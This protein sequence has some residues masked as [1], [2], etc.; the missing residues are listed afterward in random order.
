MGP[1]GGGFGAG[2]GFEHFGAQPGASHAHMQPQPGDPAAPIN[3]MLYGAGSGF[4]RSGLGAYGERLFG[5]SRDYVQSNM[6]RY[7]SSQD[8]P[9]YF[10][11][12][13][14][15]VRN[16]LKVILCPFLHKGHWTRIAEQVAGGLTYKPPKYDINAPDLYIPIMA[17]ATYMVVGG[18]AMGL[19]KKFT[20]M[21]VNSRFTT[22]LIGWALE[23]V[24]LRFILYSLGSGDAPLMD[25]IAYA[26]Y[27]FVGV[28]VALLSWL[29]WHHS[30]YVVVA[31]TG[32]CMAAFLVKTMKRVL[33]AETRNYDRDSSRHRYLLLLMSIAQFPLVLWLGRLGK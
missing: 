11:V 20:P 22:G 28:T 12:S 25:L 26:G 10:Q 3:D 2:S 19:E 16:K 5:S 24:L 8:I 17:F 23:V 27:V 31:W 29:V 33:F 32:L 15:Y 4:I 13:D 7:F 18:L 1:G 9:Y 30:Y 6:T 14:S 21:V